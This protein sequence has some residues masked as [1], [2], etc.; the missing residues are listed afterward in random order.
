MWLENFEN[1]DGG[2]VKKPMPPAA[3]KAKPNEKPVERKREVKHKK[4]Q[5]QSH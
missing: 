1:D 5:E 4:K 2:V 3:P